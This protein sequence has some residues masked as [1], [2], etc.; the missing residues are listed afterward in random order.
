ME[1]ERKRGERRRFLLSL[2]LVLF[3]FFVTVSF[4]HFCFLFVC[5]CLHQMMALSESRSQCSFSMFFSCFY[6]S[7]FSG[8]F[9]FR[10]RHSFL[11]SFSLFQPPPPPHCHRAP[12]SPSPPPASRRPPSRLPSAGRR[13]QETFQGRLEARE[14]TGERGRSRALP[15]LSLPSLFPCSSLSP[16]LLPTS[17]SALAT[18]SGPSAPLTSCLF[19]S[20]SSGA[21][22]SLS[23]ASNL[24]QLE[25]AVRSRAPSEAST[26]QTSPSVFS[27]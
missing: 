23:S 3:F 18:S 13:S 12:R 14:E 6:K 20:T 1:G 11:L 9:V 26:T 10:R 27:K 22:A 5:F 25:S 21:P 4:S 2:P 8:F 7:S 19:A 24:R 15:R 16:L 17:P